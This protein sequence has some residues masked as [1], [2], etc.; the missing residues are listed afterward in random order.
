M[1]AFI[2]VVC[3]IAVLLAWYVPNRPQDPPGGGGA[4]FSSLSF[5]AYRPGESPLAD[6]FP[7]EAEADEDMALVAKVSNGVRTYSALEGDFDTAALAQKH[8][9]KLWQG[10]WLGAD[11]AKKMPKSPVASR[12]RINTPTPS[13]AS[14]SATKCCCGA[15]CRPPN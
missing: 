15:T 2:V 13:Y 4:K 1:R 3:A 5:A 8:G 11:R 7:T 12:S 9:L 14:W 6:R 10:I